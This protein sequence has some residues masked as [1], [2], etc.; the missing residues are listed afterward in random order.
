MMKPEPRLCWV[1]RLTGPSPRPKRSRKYWVSGSSR[2]ARRMI[3]V[4]WIVTTELLTLSTRGA[5]DRPTS[6]GVGAAWAS[7]SA[8]TNRTA[9]E[10]DTRGLSA[11]VDDDPAGG[12]VGGQGHRDLVSEHHADPVLAQLAPEVGQDLVTVLQL[13]LE[14]ASRQ[15]LDDAA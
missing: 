13:D 8:A 1:S 4:L 10:I 5:T 15:D 9:A 11:A 3:L 12:I 14:I 7:S 6:E 2:T